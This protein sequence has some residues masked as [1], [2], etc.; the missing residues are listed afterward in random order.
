MDTPFV[1]TPLVLPE[2]RGN[3]RRNHP[4]GNHLFVNTKKGHWEIKGRF[5]K[6]VVLANVP[7]FRFS[8]RG[9]IRQ[10]H[11][12]GNHPFANPRKKGGTIRQSLAIA[13][14]IYRQ[15]ASITWCDLFCQNWPKMITSHDVLQPL[16]QVLSASRDVIISGH[17][18][19][20][21]LQRVFTLGDA[22]WLPNLQNGKP[23]WRKNPGKTWKKRENGPRPGGR[24]MAR[25]EKWTLKWD[26]GQ[27]LAVVFH[28]GGHFSATSGMGPFHFLAHLYGIFAP[29]RFPIRTANCHCDRNQNREKVGSGK[30]GPVQFKGGLNQGPFALRRLLWEKKTSKKGTGPGQFRTSPKKSHKKSQRKFSRRSLGWGSRVFYR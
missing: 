25:M 20:S 17:K 2:F 30:T 14:A 1:D 24:K 22:C 26:F 15:E 29:D 21:K 3:I 12:F 18:F 6:R 13:V 4:F 5:R 27:V 28:I 16:K 19:G 23:A 10:N 9:N 8:F 7:S 11:P